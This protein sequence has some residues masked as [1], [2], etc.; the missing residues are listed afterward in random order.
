MLLLVTSSDTLH[1]QHAMC[2][3]AAAAA[4]AA[5]AGAAAT[6]AMCPS[7]TRTSLC[8][9]QAQAL[10]HC[11]W[12]PGNALQVYV[13][14]STGRTGRRVVQLLRA[15]GYKVRAGVRVSEWVAE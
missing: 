3:S 13:A 2:P 9:P 15:A 6:R 8:Q 11:C 5:A 1:Q 10:Q 4:A 7:A 14:G 12:S